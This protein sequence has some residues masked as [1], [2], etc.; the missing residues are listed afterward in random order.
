[1]IDFIQKQLEASERLFN[2]ML[3]DHKDRA[4]NLQLWIDM[5]ESFQKKLEAR[6]AEIAALRT[7]LAH[8]EGINAK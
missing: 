8:Y 3:E 7:K 2:M 6:D 5:N 4:N 1:M